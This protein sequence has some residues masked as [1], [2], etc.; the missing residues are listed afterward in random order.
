MKKHNKSKLDHKN[1]LLDNFQPVPLDAFK[2]PQNSEELNKFKEDYKDFEFKSDANNIDPTRI[3][4]K[5]NLESSVANLRNALTPLYGLASMVL[6]LEK[7]P[8]LLF[9]VIRAAKDSLDLNQTI[10][11]LLVKIEKEIKQ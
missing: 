1:H 3:L 10:S 6:Q 5:A 11:D 2:F 9:I 7:H 8:D 4:K